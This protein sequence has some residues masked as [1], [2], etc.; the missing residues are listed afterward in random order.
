MA[1]LQECDQQPSKHKQNTMSLSIVVKLKS[2]N[3][4]LWTLDRCY[5]YHGVNHRNFKSDFCS[6]H[7]Q[8]DNL[9]NSLPYLNAVAFYTA[10]VIALEISFK[11]CQYFIMLYTLM[12]LNA[13]S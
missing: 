13:V 9:G 6:L 11:L 8:N 5:G 2:A 12:Y 1:T 10:L 7:T 4:S 3:T